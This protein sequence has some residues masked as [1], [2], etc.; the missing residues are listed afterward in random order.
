MLSDKGKKTSY[1]QRRKSKEAKIEMQKQP[2]PQN[3]A[4]S[5]IEKQPNP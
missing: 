3:P 2:K 1:D 5:G 4:S